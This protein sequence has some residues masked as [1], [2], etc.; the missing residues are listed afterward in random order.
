MSGG[1]AGREENPSMTTFLPSSARTHQTGGH[2]LPL[3][4]TL[5]LLCS[6]NAFTQGVIAFANNTA[7][8]VTNCIT[9][10]RIPSGGSFVAALYYGTSE[11]S[12]TAVPGFAGFTS[13]GVF[14]DGT[15]TLT[16]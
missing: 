5:C 15:R 4:A 12:L 9:G 2:W 7:S 11:Q 3:A 16:G 1:I 13:P 6:R 10:G 8:A 14:N